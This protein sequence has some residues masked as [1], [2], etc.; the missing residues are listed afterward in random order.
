MAIM[1]SVIFLIFLPQLAVPP[2][3]ESTPKVGKRFETIQTSFETDVNSL[4]GTRGVDG[5]NPGDVNTTLR[6]AKNATLSSIPPKDKPLRVYVE[7]SFPEPVDEAGPAVP[8]QE[9]EKRFSLVRDL[10]SRLSRLDS[11]RL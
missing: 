2:I 6:Q 4:N 1:L 5:Y 10:L 7:R 8:K 11:F 9:V 3:G